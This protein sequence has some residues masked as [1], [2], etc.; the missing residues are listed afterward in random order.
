MKAPWWVAPASTVLFGAVWPTRVSGADQVPATGAII[1]ASNHLG[2]LDGP[3]LVGVA[4]RW[5]HCLIKSDM[6]QGPV[7]ALLRS[8]G[9]IPVQRAT[10]DREALSRA[11]AVLAVGDAV[12][13]FPEGGRGRGDVGSVRQGVAWLALRSGAR[14]VPVACLGTRRTGESKSHWPAPRRRLD[15]VFGPPLE[16]SARPGVPGRIALAEAT[17]TLR[18]VLAAHVAA[19]SE[20]TG[21]PLPDDL[22]WS[23]ARTARGEHL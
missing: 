8:T 13:I 10:V 15:V 23:S 4:P 21:Q 12:G 19:A 1:Y 20:R 9:Q 17:A 18:E 11:L 6:F 2:F 7:G 14:V 5:P 16:L 22:G 3:M